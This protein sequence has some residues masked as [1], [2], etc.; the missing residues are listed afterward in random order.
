M[1]Q[2]E[3]IIIESVEQP[4]TIL[5]KSPSISRYG[6]CGVGDIITIENTRLAIRYY[7]T[8]GKIKLYNRETKDEISLREND[9]WTR[10]AT[11]NNRAKIAS[12]IA[13][14]INKKK[15]QFIEGLMKQP[16]LNT[17][18]S[19]VCMNPLSFITKND[20]PKCRFTKL[21]KYTNKE[22]YKVSSVVRSR[23]DKK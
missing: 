9:I 23:K 21:C 12:E 5:S 17:G 19:D 6:P 16:S 10:K 11:R 3:T 2:T 20:C 14:S 13:L 15:L 4:I 8:S 1:S 22:N 18:A 7:I